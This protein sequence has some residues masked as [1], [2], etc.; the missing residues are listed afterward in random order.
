MAA[1][2]DRSP[3]EQVLA[4][5][6]LVRRGTAFFR[7][8]LDELADSELD[9]PSL[10]AGWTRRHVIAHVGYN[11]RAIARL[12]TWAA[13]GE[14]TPM[15]SSPESRSEEIEL[16]ATLSPVALRNLVEHAAID[17]DVRWRDLPPE[18]WHVLV[19][20]AQGRTVPAEETV[21]MRTR[22]VWLHTVDLDSGATF[23]Q[24]P[25]EVLLRLV[26]DVHRAWVGR[27]GV[28]VPELRT[29][30]DGLLLGGDADAQAISGELAAVA[31]WV[32]GRSGPAVW[33]DLAWSRGRPQPAPRW[34]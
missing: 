9:E 26:Q 1:R 3:D 29:V 14:E 31:A 2:V 17:L 5:L 10:L 30:G 16:G 19:R 12:V 32:T 24:V 11:A 8:Q 13:T 28:V 22:E 23:A 33:G 15:Y 7:R 25:E 21:W 20:T 6:A 4:T 27:E 18:S 34:I